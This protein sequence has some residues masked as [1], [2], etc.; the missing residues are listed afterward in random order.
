MTSIQAARMRAQKALGARFDAQ[1]LKTFHDVVLR[2]GA[3]PLAVLD[4][5]VDA[6]IASHR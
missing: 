6:W 2:N 5:E 4:G 1:A 3:L